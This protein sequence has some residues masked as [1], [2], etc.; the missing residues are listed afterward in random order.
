MQNIMIIFSI[1]L[2]IFNLFLI[3]VLF[4]SVEFIEEDDENE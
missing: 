4:S 3:L 1:L 2:N